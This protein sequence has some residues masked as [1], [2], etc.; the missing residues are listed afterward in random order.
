[1]LFLVWKYICRELSAPAVGEVSDLEYSSTIV[2]KLN[3]QAAIIQSMQVL[4]T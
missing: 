4:L 3:K 2:E 1:M